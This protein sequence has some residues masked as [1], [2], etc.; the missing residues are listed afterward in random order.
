LQLWGPQGTIK[1]GRS[2][3][4]ATNLDDDSS[5]VLSVVIV[6]SLIVINEKQTIR[7]LEKVSETSEYPISVSWRPW[8]DRSGCTALSTALYTFLSCLILNSGY[9]S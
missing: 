1:C 4:V 7:D 2:L 5:F 6:L 9:F 3:S 8:D